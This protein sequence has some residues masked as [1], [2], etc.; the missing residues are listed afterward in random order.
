MQADIYLVQKIINLLDKYKKLRQ[1]SGS[2]ESEWERSINDQSRLLFHLSAT[3]KMYL[4]KDSILS[5]LIFDDFEKTEK[6]FIQ[7]FLK[8]DD[9]FFDIGA[10]VGLHTLV[11]CDILKEGGHIYSFEPTPGIYSRLLENLAENNF[12]KIVSPVNM[13]VSD[14][15]ESLKFN[16]ST[17]GY[18]G[19]NSFATLKYIQLESQ[20]EIKVITIDAFVNDNHIEPDSISLIKIDVE[21]WEIKVLSG[22]KNLFND[23]HFEACFLI[24]FTEENMFRAGSS[25][26]NLYNFMVDKG[27]KWYEYDPTANQI[28]HAELKAYYPYENLIATK[29]PERINNRL[30]GF[31]AS[32]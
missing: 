6:L 12:N 28:N 7:R 29:S 23:A 25:C 21:G 15:S 20:V 26:R 3:V 10:N 24:E 11:A 31:G 17:N 16:M 22:M 2:M 4:Y 30:S 18:D 27:Y 19:W 5:K 8:K 13:G 14:T 32:V 1:R 9:V